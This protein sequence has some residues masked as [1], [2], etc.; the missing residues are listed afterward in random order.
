MLPAAAVG[1]CRAKP[2]TRQIFRSHPGRDSFARPEIGAPTANCGDH[3]R[4]SGRN[5]A[6]HLETRVALPGAPGLH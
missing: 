2:L 1:G 5:S 4:E 6:V 3:H